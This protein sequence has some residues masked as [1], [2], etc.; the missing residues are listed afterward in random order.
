[1]C[2]TTGEVRSPEDQLSQK[3]TEVERRRW[4]RLPLP[5]PIFMR[6]KDS[7]GK[8]SLEFATALN[9]SAGGALVAGTRAIP[10]SSRVLLEI[11]KAPLASIAASPEGSGLIEASTARITH[12]D[13]YHLIAVKFLDPLTN[14][15]SAAAARRRKLTSPK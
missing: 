2:G 7:S 3:K 1:M 15:T 10:L 12:V 14:Q 6:S 8:E 5:I 13:D 9:I 11:P 4:V